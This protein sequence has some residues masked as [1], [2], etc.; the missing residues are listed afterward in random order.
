MRRTVRPCPQTGRRQAE[1]RCRRSEARRAEAGSDSTVARRPSAGDVA[2]GIRSRAGGSACQFSLPLAGLCR[3]SAREAGSAEASQRRSM[4]RSEFMLWRIGELP[5]LTEA[6]VRACGIR[7]RL[8]IAGLSYAG[9]SR[10]ATASHSLT[11][12]SGPRRRR[13]RAAPR[14]RY[15]SCTLVHPR[16]QCRAAVGAKSGRP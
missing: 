7:G 11:G 15:T 1:A 10:A 5:V 3:T 12:Q 14:N 16:H 9:A 4:I 6:N 13:K 8:R 2:P